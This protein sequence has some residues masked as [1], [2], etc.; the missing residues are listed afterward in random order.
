MTSAALL[1]VSTTTVYNRVGG[2][3]HMRIMDGGTIRFRESQGE[4]IFDI[5][6]RAPADVDDMAYV[7][8]RGQI[9][10]QASRRR[11]RAT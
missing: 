9:G 8:I 6:T 4:E 5:M 11:L 1:R 2:W 3:P 10:M 7:R